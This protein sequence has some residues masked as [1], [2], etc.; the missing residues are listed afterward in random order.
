MGDRAAALHGLLGARFWES[1]LHDF[2]TQPKVRFL[3]GV[4]LDELRHG[5]PLRALEGLTVLDVVVFDGRREARGHL[6]IPR[7]V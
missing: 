3:L 5:F 4:F 1:E 2:V 6:R 7:V